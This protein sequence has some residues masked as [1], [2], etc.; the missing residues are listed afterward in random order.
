[1][2]PTVQVIATTF[3]GTRAA[4]ATAVPL[5]KGSGAKLVLLVPRLV[6]YAV[7]LDNHVEPAAFFVKRYRELIED[8]GG[9]ARIEV[10]VCRSLDGIV[11]RVHADGSTLVVGGPTG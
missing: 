10:V 6:S 2:Q 11:T 7:D 5:A 1:M 8:L 3:D 4:L 9:E